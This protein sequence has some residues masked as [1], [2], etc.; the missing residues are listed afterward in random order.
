MSD[1]DL[2]FEKLE[3]AEKVLVG[4]GA[5]LSAAAGL[6]YFDTKVFEKYYP[7]M[8]RLGYRCQYELVGMRDEDWTV[9][10]KWAW[11]ATHVNYVRRIFPPAELY[12]KLL[13]LLEG[14][15]YFVVTSNADRQFMRN[16][17]DEKRLFEYQGNYDNM[18]C[19]ERCTPHTWDN[20][21]YLDRIL[22]SID[23]EKFECPDEALPRCPYCGGLAEM[24]FRGEDYVQRRDVYV[25]FIQ[26][27]EGKSLCII[28][29]GVGFNTPGVIRWPFER[30]TY[31]L[32]TAHLF[33]INSGYRELR[34]D[35]GD[36]DIPAEIADRATHIRQDAAQVIE[37]L[38]AR[39]FKIT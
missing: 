8:R 34:N 17:I 5:G 21:P 6:S 18:G 33:R 37:E 7:D 4:A 12:K 32:D 15:D 20:K 2:L 1:T 9:G 27:C 13:G 14:R 25:D 23:H 38:Y 19:A 22:E 28:E 29:L 10:R 11:W 3:S 36:G 35:R 26:S 16:G 24:C 39:K 31:Q 30:I